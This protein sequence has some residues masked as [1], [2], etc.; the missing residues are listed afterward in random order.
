[1]FFI[2]FDTTY[3]YERREKFLW[4]T[5]RNTDTIAG[6]LLSSG[7]QNGGP[8]S[9]HNTGPNM[10]KEHPV[11]TNSEIALH[12]RKCP[13]QS[14][15]R[16]QELLFKN[17]KIKMYKNNIVFV[18]YSSKICFPTTK[19]KRRLRILEDMIIK[20]ISWPKMNKNRD[21]CRHRNEERHSLYCS[22]NIV[23]VIKCRKLR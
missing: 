11:H 16:N 20:Q 18:I 22:S 8:S 4:T 3:R 1:M 21:W 13:R 19:E 14:R 15:G 5:F 2:P 9:E 12:K 17:L 6:T 7:Q 23:N 10:D